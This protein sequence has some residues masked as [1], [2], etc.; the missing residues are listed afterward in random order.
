MKRLVLGV[1]KT[2]WTTFFFTSSYHKAGRT[3]AVAGHVAA[4]YENMLKLR[5]E[6]GLDCRTCADFEAGSIC[7]NNETGRHTRAEMSQPHPYST[8]HRLLHL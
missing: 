1:S 2:C 7:N 6:S 8:T 5:P 4:Q 3:L